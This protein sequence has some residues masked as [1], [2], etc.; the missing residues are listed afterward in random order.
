MIT[1]IKLVGIVVSDTDAAYDFYANKLGMTVHTDTMLG[2]NRWLEFQPAG[3]ETTLA[4]SK[5]FQASDKDKIGIFHSIAFLTDD[6]NHAYEKMVAAGVHFTQPPERQPWGDAAALFADP[7]GNTFCL[8]EDGKQ[9]N[10]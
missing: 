8:V 7:D 2:E 10:N 1:R 3:A 6:I 5:P 4:V 9:Q